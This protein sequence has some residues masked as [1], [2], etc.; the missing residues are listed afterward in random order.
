VKEIANELF[1]A[2]GTVRNLSSV[3]IKK[4]NGRNRFDAA[5]IALEQGWL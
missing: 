1:L 3:V 4:L 2:A 5:R